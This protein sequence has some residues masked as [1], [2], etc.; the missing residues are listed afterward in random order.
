[1]RLNVAPARL[2]DERALRSAARSTVASGLIAVL[3]PYKNALRLQKFQ[4]YIIFSPPL[5]YFYY[6]FLV[7]VPFNLCLRTCA[8]VH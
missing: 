8:E 1:M 7:V 5:K 3:P 2:P 6:S 4:K